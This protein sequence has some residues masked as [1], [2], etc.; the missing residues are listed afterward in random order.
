MPEDIAATLLRIAHS[1]ERLAGATPHEAD[2]IIGSAFRWDG[3]V[4]HV[5]D[6]PSVLP[7]S[8]FAGVDQQLEALA[9]NI[10]ALAKGVTP[11]RNLRNFTTTP[12]VKPY[13]C[14]VQS[15]CR[16]SLG[17]GNAERVMREQADAGTLARR[18]HAPIGIMPAGILGAGERA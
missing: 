13:G 11:S 7:T 12:C 17:T 14:P 1:L 9:R 15:A 10:G 6:S 4:L 2:P 18:D 5:V 16:A 3:A 8:R